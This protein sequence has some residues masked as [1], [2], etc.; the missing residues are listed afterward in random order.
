MHCTPWHA[1]LIVEEMGHSLYRLPTD[2]HTF[3]PSSSIAVTASVSKSHSP[4]TAFASATA[5]AITTAT[6]AVT[7]VDEGVTS[8]SSVAIDHQ[9]AQAVPSSLPNHPDTTVSRDHA[10]LCF[11]SAG[12]QHLPEVHALIVEHGANVWNWLP[13]AGIA[14][15]LDDIAHGRAYGVLALEQ[16]TVIGVVTYCLST[17]FDRYLTPPGI[18]KPCGYVCEAVVHRDRTGRGVGTRL[19]RHAVAELARRDVDAVFI[20]RHEENQASAGM[21]RNAGFVEID[22][23]AD[24]ARRPHGSG[25]TTVCWK[26]LNHTDID[27]EGCVPP[28]AA[29]FWGPMF[30]HGHTDTHAS[31][32]FRSALEE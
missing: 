15:H 27:D 21:M 23:F 3:A 2:P 13:S 31:V 5:T 10:G 26:Q 12:A 14:Q 29:P 24:A 19:L 11:V 28:H 4:V 6:A 22:T 20:S 25:R 16:G 17:D 18:G 32:R 30:Y 8:S 1:C 9:T 7:A